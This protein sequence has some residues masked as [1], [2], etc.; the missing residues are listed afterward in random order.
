LVYQPEEK[1]ADNRAWTAGRYAI[2]IGGVPAGWVMSAEGGGANSD[3]VV[4]KIGPDLIQHKHLAGVKYEDITVN[5]GAGMAKNYFEWIETTLKHETNSKGRKD[6]SIHSCDYDG[7][8]KHTLDFFH[9]MIS[10]LGFP[11]CDAASKDAAKLVTKIAIETSRG[12]KGSGKCDLK[13]DAAKA[14]RWTAR[15]FK[16]EIA[17]LDCTRVNKVEAL[18][19]KQKIAENPIG[20]MRDY[21]KVAA[22]IEFPH[23]VVTCNDSHADNWLKWHEDFVIHG[24]NDQGAEKT[25]ALHYLSEDLS[26]TLFTI[27]F[28]GLGIFKA[29]HDKR[30]AHNENVSRH[31]F[32]MYCHWFEFKS[33]DAV[34]A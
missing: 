30:E 25:G 33:G 14:K 16:L 12:K 19:V 18:T 5:C 22:N 23:L 6:G 21:E 2:D 8:I 10:E 15:N 29:T 24:K 20:E 32:E 13:I 31:K 27:N 34:W 28:H 11:A 1:M 4:E 26:K 17:G 9:G 3:V 7:N